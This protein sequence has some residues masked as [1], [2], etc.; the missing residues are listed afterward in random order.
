LY[1]AAVVVVLLIQLTYFRGFW[2]AFARSA[3]H[4]FRTGR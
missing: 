1:A 2:S 3:W 4:S